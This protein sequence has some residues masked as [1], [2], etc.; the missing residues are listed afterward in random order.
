MRY[1]IKLFIVTMRVKRLET[2]YRRNPTLRNLHKWSDCCG[3]LYK[4]KYSPLTI[5]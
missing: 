4:M 1:R 2:I 5:S 3:T